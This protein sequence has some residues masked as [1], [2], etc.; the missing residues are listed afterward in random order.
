MTTGHIGT[1]KASNGNILRNPD[2]VLER[3]RQYFDQ[4]FNEEFPHPSIPPTECIQGPVLP[5]A[6]AEVSEAIKKMKRNK[7]TGPDD[8]PVDV[9]KL[10]GESGAAWLSKIFNRILME[11]KT[12]EVWQMSTT[13][14]IWKERGD[15]ADCSSYRPIRLLCHTMKIFERILDSR[16]RAIVSTTPNQCGFVKGCGTTDAIHAARLLVERHREKNRSVHLAFLDLEKAFDRVPRDLIWMAL[17]I[18]GIPEEYVRWIKMLYSRPTSVV[19]C[20]AGTSKPFPVQVGVHQGSALSPLLF[21]LCVDAITRDIQKSHPWCLLYADDVMLAAE[22]REE[23]EEEVQLWK[24]RLQ[25]YGLRLNIAKTEYMECGAKIE[26]GTICVDGNNLK[27]V[28]CFKYLGSRITSTG[29]VLPDAYGRANSAWMKW[30]TTTGILCDKKMP[31]RLK[32]KVYRTVVRPVVLYGTEC[33]TATKVTKQVLHTMEMRM[34]RWSMGVTLKDKVSNEMVRSTFGVAPIIDKMRE[35]RLRWFGHVLRGEGGSVAKTALT[36]EVKGVRPRGRPETR[37]LDCVKTDMAEVQLTIRDANN[38]NKGRRDAVQRTLRLRGTNA[39]KKK[40]YPVKDELHGQLQRVVDAIP[41]SELVVSAGDFNAHVGADRQGWERAPGRFAV[42]EVNDNGSRLLSFATTNKL[43][44]GNSY[45]QHPRKH[46]LAWRNPMGHD[47]TVLDYV[48]ISSRFMSSFKDVR[49]MRGPDCGSDHYL[50][51]AV[52]QLRLK[53][54]TSKSHPV[55]KL[56][57]SSLITPPSQ[58]LIQIALPNRFA[59]LAMGTTADEEEKQMSD[60]VL[61]CAKSLCPVIRYRTQSWISNE[62]LQLV[63]KRK[64]AKLVDFNCYRQLNQ[65]LR[66]RVEMEREAY[67]NRLADELEEAAGRNDYRMLYR[68]IGRLSG[69]ARATDDNIRKA[70]GTFARLTAKRLERWKEFFSELYNHESP[71]GP[72]LSI[73][74]PRNAFLDGE[75]NIDEIRKAVRSLENGKSPGVD[76]ITAEAIKAGGEVLLRRLHSL[77]SLVWQSEVIPATWKRACGTNP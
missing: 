41:Q 67:W 10:M 16:L 45:F 62:C 37:W 72:P 70:D 13:V 9:W 36:L 50:L 21:I 19:R 61:E 11:G 56:D 4:M 12:P 39:R 7:A 34:L 8:V 24:E 54:T 30:R 49:A 75:P 23:L 40:K 53:R 31:I 77:I 18:H 5:I 58:Q 71:Q 38:R 29:D 51:R 76:N 68:T 63:D 22:T 69:K 42:R 20:A 66:R 46:Q 17:R 48:L 73:Q 3:W 15:S 65:E 47:S 27:K 55:P 52:M 43:V 2:D 14:P 59:T 1:I 74:T 57:W 32:S 64:R 28:E 35:A 6:P 60:D 44:I 26:D 25:R 33:W